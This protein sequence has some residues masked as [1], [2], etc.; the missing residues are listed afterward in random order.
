MTILLAEDEDSVRNLVALILERAGFQVILC[1]DGEQA[2]AVLRDPAQTID[3]LVT[4]VLMPGVNGLHVARQA[5]C[6]RPGLKVLLVS[7]CAHLDL[8]EMEPGPLPDYLAKPFLPQALVAKVHEVL[9][10]RAAATQ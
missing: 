10:L 2:L 1:A 9:G 8:L 7:G 6:L 5:A 4:D 3:L